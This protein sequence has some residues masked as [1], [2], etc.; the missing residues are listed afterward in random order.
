MIQNGVATVYVSNMDR[1]VRFY[2]ETLGLKLAWRFGDH[3]ATI[4]ADGLTIGLH[5]A[6][7]ESPAGR[8]GSITIG[9]QVADIQDAI[10]R[11]KGHNVK[12]AG[13]FNEGKAG[14]F[15]GFE[16]PDG[17]QLYLCQLRA[18]YNEDSLKEREVHA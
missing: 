12:M 15:V 18:G 4:T 14:A 13:E 3:W 5:P 16:D 17:N 2:T 1:S 7:A 10:A 11:L 9:F 6:T 8:H